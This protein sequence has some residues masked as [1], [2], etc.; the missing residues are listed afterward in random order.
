MV[1]AGRR[2]EGRSW[3]GDRGPKTTRAETRV[4]DDDVQAPQIERP[5][6]EQ[7][8]IYQ[9]STRCCAREGERE[10]REGG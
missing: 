4:H 2:S 5:E 1:G 8:G 6:F 10:V 7:V 9:A 3:E